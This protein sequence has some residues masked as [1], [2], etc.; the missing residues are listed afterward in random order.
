MLRFQI[1]NMCDVFCP[2][3]IWLLVFI[4]LHFILFYYYYYYFYYY[5]YIM[6]Y[7]YLFFIFSFLFSLSSLFFF[8]LHLPTPPIFSLSSHTSPIPP[9]HHMPPHLSSI[10]FLFYFISPLCRELNWIPQSCRDITIIREEYR[11][12]P[13]RLQYFL[14]IYNTTTT[15]H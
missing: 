3:T 7:F 14:S 2:L 1:S 11:V 8:L 12:Q 4:I 9:R 13:Q 15:P 10:I 6:F 5:Y